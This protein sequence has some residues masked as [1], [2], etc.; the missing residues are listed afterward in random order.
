MLAISRLGRWVVL[1]LCAVSFTGCRSLSKKSKPPSDSPAT[2]DSRPASLSQPTVLPIGMVHHVDPGG[3]FV[4]IRSS[5]SFKIEAGTPLTVRG[6]RGEAIAQLEASPA[7]KGVFL[8]AD[9]LSGQPV[10]GRPVTMEHSPRDVEA[11]S[12]PLSEG[13]GSSAIQVLE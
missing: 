5:R 2:G 6:E 1:L 12:P 11:T 3:G 7:R 4:L 10:T 8:S 13:E 9:V